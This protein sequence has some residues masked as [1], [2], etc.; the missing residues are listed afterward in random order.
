MQQN[1]CPVCDQIY[2]AS[3]ASEAVCTLVNTPSVNSA[4]TYNLSCTSACTQWKLYILDYPIA[5]AGGCS[6]LPCL[7]D[8]ASLSSN[9]QALRNQIR[10]SSSRPCSLTFNATTTGD[11][12]MLAQSFNL[13][14]RIGEVMI[15]SVPSSPES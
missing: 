2:A 14:V 8:T 11:L 9:T 6:S 10:W 7:T 5:L 15:R 4:A 12:L 13:S 3:S 1:T